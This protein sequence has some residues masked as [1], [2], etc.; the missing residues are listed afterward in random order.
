MVS[1]VMFYNIEQNNQSINL[2]TY[3]ASM[4]EWN[5]YMW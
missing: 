1:M 5:C 4:D 2:C 3:K